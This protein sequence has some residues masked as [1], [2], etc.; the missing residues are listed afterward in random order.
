M[1]WVTR[2]CE[3][4]TWTKLCISHKLWVSNGHTP[5]PIAL[6]N[7]HAHSGRAGLP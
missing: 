2:D 7:A 5:T 6:V 1:G 3:V 4:A